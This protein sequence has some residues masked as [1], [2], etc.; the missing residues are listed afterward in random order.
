MKSIIAAIDFSPMSE[1]VVAQAVALARSLAGK[2]IL[3]TVMVEPVYLPEY[4]PPPK[5]TAKLTVAHERT[6][7]QRLVEI[8]T[9]LRAAA[10]AADV[11][12]R[13]GAAAQQVLALA[14]ETDAAFIVIGS[15]GHGAV[16]ELFLGRRH[17]GGE[18]HHC[19]ARRAHRVGTLGPGPRQ[20]GARGDDD[21]LDHHGDLGL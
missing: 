11:V 13:R 2:V 19:F 10:V 5:R 3:I 7:K 16:F 12:L 21:I 4:A 14:E 17:F 18:G 8:Q 15:H 20:I 1:L 6:L 9:R